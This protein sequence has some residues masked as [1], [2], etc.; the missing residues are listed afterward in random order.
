MSQDLLTPKQQQ[1]LKLIA[2]PLYK[3][4]PV[5]HLERTLGIMGTSARSQLEM[6]V[7]KLGGGTFF[8]AVCIGVKKGYVLLDDPALQERARA[9]MTS[10]FAPLLKLHPHGEVAVA[11]RDSGTDPDVFA[12]L[13]DEAYATVGI[14]PKYQP[15][16]FAHPSLA[17]A[18]CYVL[19][20]AGQSGRNGAR[21]A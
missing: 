14:V 2:W 12:R 11:I 3:G 8:E 16:Q 15:K 19:Q 10:H 4:T 18:I 9:L 21:S 5:E 1:A 17:P 6:M 13:L 20:Q 7:S